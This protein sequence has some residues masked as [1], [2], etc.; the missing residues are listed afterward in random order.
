MSPDNALKAVTSS[1]RMALGTPPRALGPGEPADLV[2]VE[3]Q[4]LAS[5]IAGASPRRTVYRGGRVVSVTTVRT[6]YDLG[7]PPRADR[8]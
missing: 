6:C 4:D 8:Q 2:L 3:G 1:A 5:A 7:G